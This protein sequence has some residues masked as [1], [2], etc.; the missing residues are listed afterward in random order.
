MRWSE[1]GKIIP[2]S[3]EKINVCVTSYAKICFLVYFYL[4]N[5]LWMGAGTKLVE[6]LHTTQ[7]LHDFPGG[8]WLVLAHV[9]QLAQLVHLALVATCY[10]M[11]I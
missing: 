4:F 1:A 2:E 6:I 5:V 9:A 8:P 11:S 10:I 3:F 7:P